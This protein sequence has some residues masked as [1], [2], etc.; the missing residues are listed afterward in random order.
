MSEIAVLS[1]EVIRIS[2]QPKT[3]IYLIH[4]LILFNKSEYIDCHSAPHVKPDNTHPNQQVVPC[5]VFGFC[6]V[7][8]T[9]ELTLQ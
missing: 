9:P 4:N 7:M 1:C 5:L 6:R 2:A 8:A 3:D